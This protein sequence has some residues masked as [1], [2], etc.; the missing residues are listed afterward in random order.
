MT[1]VNANYENSLQQLFFL[2]LR[3]LSL[4]TERFTYELAEAGQAPG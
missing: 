1:S 2:P 3:K 4:L